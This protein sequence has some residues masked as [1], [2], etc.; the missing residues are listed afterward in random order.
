MSHQISSDCHFAHARY[1]SVTHDLIDQLSRTTN[2]QL[3][4]I[5]KLEHFPYTQN[6]HYYQ[7]NK[8][9]LL[10]KFKQQ[11][12]DHK[13]DQANTSGA[14]GTTSA[15][16][17]SAPFTFGAP[18]TSTTFGLPNSA[19][20]TA[21]PSFAS[22]NPPAQAPIAPKGPSPEAIQAALTS[23]A[24]I[25]INVKKEDL[26]KLHGND[27]WEEEIEMMAD[28]QAYLKISRKVCLNLCILAVLM[29]S[30]A[31][32][33]QCSTSHRRLSDSRIGQ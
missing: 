32:H 26:S 5:E 22:F 20:A 13:K 1:R 7:E 10:A 29:I 8:D 3:E 25:G 19:A 17:V 18:N 33:R 12:H 28:V 23:L 16:P 6:L 4:Y 24:A 21:Q 2:D 30:L 31:Y 27:A 15:A 11:R 9:K 14:A